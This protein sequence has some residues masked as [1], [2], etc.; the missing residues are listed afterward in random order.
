MTDYQ[1]IDLASR[2]NAGTD[3]LPIGSASRLGFQLLRGLP[4]HLGSDPTQ[5]LIALRPDPGSP[6]LSID[7]GGTA[8]SIVFAHRVLESS[9]LLGSEFVGSTVGN[10]TFEFEDG[11]AEVVPI[12]DRFEIGAP[13]VRSPVGRDI[14]W[15]HLPFLAVTDH[16]PEPPPRTIGQFG[17]AGYRQTGILEE[18]LPAF[19]LWAWIN[20]RPDHPVRRVRLRAETATILVGGVTI[21]HASEHPL[22]PMA[23]SSVKVTV[24]DTGA[25]LTASL[26]LRIDRGSVSLAQ[27]VM[28]SSPQAFLEDDLHGWGDGGVPAERSVYADVTANP[29][30]TLIVELGGIAVSETVWADVAAAGVMESGPVR[31]QVISPERNWVTTTVVDDSTGEPIP[32][33]IHFRSLDGIPFQPHGHHDQI[34]GGLDS[35]HVDVGGDVGLG[36]ATYAYID[37]TC[38]GWLPRT[39]V[40]VDVARGFEYEPLRT[41]V[42]IAPGQQT[43]TLRLR[44]W[45]DL[46][47]QGWFSGDT[48]VHFLS[49]EASHL[50][51]QGEDLGVVNLLQAQWGDLFTSVEEF[52]GRPSVS[53]N[54]QSIVYVGQENRQHMLGHLSLLGLTKAVMPWS[55]GGPNE[56]RIGGDL[57]AT[58][59]DWAD[60]C[61]AQGGTVILPHLPIPNGEPAALVATGRVD[62]VEIVEQTEFFHDEYYRYLNGGYRLPLVGGT[63]KMS[64][65]VPVGLNRTYVNIPAGEEFSYENWCRN[66]RLGRTFMSSGPIISLVVDGQPIG[67]TVHLP[68]RGGTVEI[69][70]TVGSAFPVGSLELIAAGVVIAATRSAG[71]ERTLT[72]DA[73]LHVTQDT[74]IA[75]RAGGPGYFD[76]PRHRDV[77]GRGMMAHTSPIYVACGAEWQRHD[78]AIAR[79]M[80][81]LIHG[82]LAHIDSMLPHRAAGERSHQHG[83]DDHRAYLRRPFLEAIERIDQRVRPRRSTGP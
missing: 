56:G 71:D 33:R 1:P 13:G 26:E 65:D 10:Y 25:P 62:A 9:M 15:G 19:F 36:T 66:L 5:C 30:A 27:S 7:L 55:T 45:T 17:K 31:I 48:H 73:R 68:R 60:R 49:T 77:W 72:V 75:A 3:I 64:S 61:H 4:F 44:R 24:H 12:R 81:T 18:P 37:G 21:G 58:L 83:E 80:L 63:D 51:A 11:R 54:G 52:T 53:P 28:A 29:S 82:S 32:C 78:P 43:L 22:I 50:E 20:P 47:R 6:E 79:Y 76:A 39:S 59:S 35:W 46:R 67:D 16:A 57:D 14:Y 23:S 2:F 40:L 69:S 70:A 41:A 38:Q 74:W 34:N 8:V 42:V